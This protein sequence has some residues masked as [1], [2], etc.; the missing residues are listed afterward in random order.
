[1]TALFTSKFC[2]NNNYEQEIPDYGRHGDTN[3]HRSTSC[4]LCIYHTIKICAQ[5]RDFVSY[6]NATSVVVWFLALNAFGT[7]IFVHD[8]VMSSP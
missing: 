7:H 6:I 8:F 4:H 3:V 2:Y 1:M 5:L